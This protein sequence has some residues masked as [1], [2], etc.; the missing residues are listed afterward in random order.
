MKKYDYIIIGSGIS[1][2]SL[3]HFLKEHSSNI[4]LIDKN[5]NICFGASGAAGAFLSPLLG[6]DNPFKALVTKALKFSTAFYKN[7]FN[8]SFNQSGTIR[9]PKNL[10]DEEKFH[11]Y[12]SSMDF[13]FIKK[14]NGYYFEIGSTIK[15]DVLCKELT[16]DIEKLLNY[17]VKTIKKIDDNW[18]L[19]DELRASKLFLCTGADTSLV[20]E[21]YFVQ[22]AVWGQKI[23]ILSSTNT[24]Y[25]YHKECS[26]SKSIE[27]NGKYKI[28]IGAT[29]NRFEEN[30]S[31]SSYNL[32]LKDINN[33]E[34]NKKTMNIMQNDTKKL[35]N[36]ADDILKLENIEIIDIKIGARASSIDYFPM[37]GS[38]VNSKDSFIKHPHIKNGA[39][40]K[41]E[42]L[43][44][45]KNL[46]TLNGVG[47]RGFVFAPYLA[48][49][50]SDFVV[51]GANMP[52]DISNFRLFK[53][54]AKKEGRNL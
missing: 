21:K 47:G 2:C 49:I 3:A 33:I 43:I 22:R 30:M 45:Y 36:R 18:I 8:E 40:I 16:K 11:S 52:E 41:N 15:P 28:S 32:K 34:H 38:L 46:Y 50:L 53:R 24:N 17:E 26:V 12:A 35:L 1:G 14:E 5:S 7:N 13:P 29:H 25:N 37:V 9:I 27:E 42:Q 20:D 54:W 6:F 19:N 51:N 31:D 23:D 10:K 4:L 44:L 48:K 39:F